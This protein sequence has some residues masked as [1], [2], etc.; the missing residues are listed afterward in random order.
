MAAY[1]LPNKIPTVL[2]LGFKD[3]DG[4]FVE[5]NDFKYISPPTLF[6]RAYTE[7]GFIFYVDPTGT[8]ISRI[9][10][11]AVDKKEKY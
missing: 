10:I 3:T 1:L 7:N 4:R 9:F 5:E 11:Y 6:V 8:E 2:K